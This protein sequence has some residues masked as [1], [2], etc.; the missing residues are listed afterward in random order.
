VR[1][2]R[3]VDISAGKLPGSLLSYTA[4]VQDAPMPRWGWGEAKGP[5]LPEP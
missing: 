5:Y 3:R 1:P 4:L 2:L